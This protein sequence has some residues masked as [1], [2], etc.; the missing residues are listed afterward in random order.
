MALD[1]ADQP[2]LRTDS[3]TDGGASAVAGLEHHLGHHFHDPNLLTLAITHA[4]AGQ[5]R[6]D[7]LDNERL[8]FL[9]DR[10][11]GLVIADLLMARFPEAP[12]GE[13]GPRLAA[14]V[15]REALAEVA[16][17]MGLGEHLVVAPSDA[18]G[19]ARDNPKL[20][21]DACEALIAA[22]YLDGGLAAA[23]A[24]IARAWAPLIAGVGALPIEPKTMLQEWAQG[25]GK[26][27]PSYSVIETAGSAH[28]PTFQVKVA[29]EGVEPATATGPSKRAAEKGAALALLRKLAL[30]PAGKIMT[31]GRP[32]NT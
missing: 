15:R 24:F 29:V 30:V 14:L 3:L 5:G 19:G 4:G 22:L 28:S 11:L 10:V 20:L 18:A 8:E 23:Q 25:Q 17:N 31:E 21:A 9:G 6:H 1:V 26:A 27:I 13:L 12:E 32:E 2:L 7:H 16:R